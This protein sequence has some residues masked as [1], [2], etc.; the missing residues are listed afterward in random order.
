MITVKFKMDDLLQNLIMMIIIL[1]ISNYDKFSGCI[2]KYIN[3]DSLFFQDKDLNPNYLHPLVFSITATENKKI[4]DPKKFQNMDSNENKGIYET[5]KTFKKSMAFLDITLTA[6]SNFFEKW[7]NLITWED[8][9][10]S[11]YFI[12]FT[13]IAYL[14]IEVLTMRVLIFIGSKFLILINIFITLHS[15]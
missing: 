11:L 15:M 5:Y 3:F 6:I 13:F 14:F 1:T 8:K 2:S 4:L 10:R 9:R 7:K 12:L